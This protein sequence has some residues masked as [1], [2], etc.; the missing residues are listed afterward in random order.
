[1]TDDAGICREASRTK[2]APATGI[3][4]EG[5]PPLFCGLEPLTFV[6]V[7]R[8]LVLYNTPSATGLTCPLSTPLFS[9][10]MC[11]CHTC[12]TRGPVIDV[13]QEFKPD[14]VLISAGYDALEADELATAS[15]QPTD[16]G[17]YVHEDA[18]VVVV[19]GV[20]GV[21][22]SGGGVEVVLV[23]VV[24]E[25]PSPA[26]CSDAF[27]VALTPPIY[28]YAGTLCD[29]LLCANRQARGLSMAPCV[30]TSAAVSVLIF[31]CSRYFW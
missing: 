1:M 7:C 30:H 6:S 5:I 25:L 22:G 21:V 4:R 14:L 2:L 27:C 17:R 28:I 15:L 3:G 23:V 13:S 9:T 29:C 16:Y 18:L 10:V 12:R 19:V 26:R 8:S 20:V 24:V 11:M 31:S